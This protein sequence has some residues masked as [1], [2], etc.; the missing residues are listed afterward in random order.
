MPPTTGSEKDS[1]PISWFHK[2]QVW[3]LIYF[4]Q[5][6]EKPPSQS[7]SWWASQNLELS[8]AGRE[9]RLQT[10]DQGTFQLSLLNSDLREGRW[11]KTHTAHELAQKARNCQR[12]CTP[13]PL[14]INN[15]PLQRTFW[16]QQK[17]RTR[18]EGPE[19]SLGSVWQ[20]LNTKGLTYF[21]IDGFKR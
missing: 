6:E 3:E 4:E 18:T 21:D 14:G 2:R 13:D 11:C 1:V 16:P 10:H 15:F 19:E 20:C 8:F 7:R 17:R 12:P 9:Q 5:A